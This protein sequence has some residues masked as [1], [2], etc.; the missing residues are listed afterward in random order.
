MDAA[1]EKAASMGEIAAANGFAGASYFSE[2]FPQRNGMLVLLITEN[3]MVN[4]EKEC[5][6]NSR[7]INNERGKTD[8]HV[9]AAEKE[10]AGKK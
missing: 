5:P 1:L 8:S 9:K 4:L 2:T 10:K 6:D 3:G 7:T